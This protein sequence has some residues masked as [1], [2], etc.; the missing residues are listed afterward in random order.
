[1]EIFGSRVAAGVL[2]RLEGSDGA[3]IIFGRGSEFGMSCSHGWA[4]GSHLLQKLRCFVHGVFLF[5]KERADA[6]RNQ[7]GWAVAQRHRTQAERR[8]VPG[9]ILIETSFFPLSARITQNTPA[10]NLYV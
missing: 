6:L 10:S 7:E 8:Q 9:Q 3:R 1:M 4:S 5:V 2:R